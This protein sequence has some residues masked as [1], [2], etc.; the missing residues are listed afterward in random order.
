MLDTGNFFRDVLGV[1]I[2]HDGAERGDVVG[3]GLYPGVDAVQQGDVADPVLREVTLHVVAGEDVVAAQS[4]QILGDDHVD[5]PGL[6][7]G[8]H[9]L[10]IRPVEVCAA[11][12]VVDVGVEN[13]QTVLLDKFIEQGLLVVDAFGWPFV[14]ILLR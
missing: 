10:E 8:D 6:N 9:A 7:V 1:H 2:I 12:A 13:G 4:A 11:P 3:C 5:L 14:L